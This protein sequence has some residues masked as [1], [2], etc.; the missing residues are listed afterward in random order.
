MA[1]IALDATYTVDPTST[2]TGVYCR[3]LIESIAALR[4]PHHF[5]LCFR[6]SRFARRQNFL[7]PAG[8]T[9]AAGRSFSTRLYQQPF[10]FWLPREAQ[11]FHSLTQRPPAFRFRREIVTVQDIFP[12]TS[13]T[14][15]TEDF[16]R[17]FAGLLLEA[18]ARAARVITPS[19][20]TTDQLLKHVEVPREKVRIIPHGVTLPT[21]LMSPEQRARERELIVGKGNE[22]ILVVGV[23]DNRK[24]ILN[25]VRVL[26]RLPARY[27][28]VLA[29]GD[30][31]GAE[32]IH[33]FIRKEQLASRV[34]AL[35]RVPDATL[36]ILYQVA[37]VLLF[38]S[39]EEGFG[40]P[41]L[42]A[43]AYGLPVV[44][45][46]ASSLPELGGDAALYVDPND[47][48]DMANKVMCAVEDETLH[49]RLIE[50]GLARAR[51]F[52]WQRA[53]EQTCQV[54]D[55]VLAA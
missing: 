16:R 54:Y 46:G 12:L 50:L 39:F 24:N 17:R 13:R 22:I 7:R 40:F 49:G 30:G 26:P 2:G 20:Y 14:Y 9:G 5:L 43:M 19:R 41:V 29:G 45:S 31:F 18:V 36:A 8:L 35:G 32:A 38:P 42:E 23:L 47:P 1:T 28:L 10:T 27:R 44:V 3:G 6:P 4:T 25:A 48:G 53:A 52:P 11:L 55:E 51:Q 21:R 33:D 15:S 34:T 37:S